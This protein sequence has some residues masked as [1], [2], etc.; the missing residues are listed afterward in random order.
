MTSVA[1][2]QGPNERRGGHY[3]H[4]AAP[5]SAEISAPEQ[6]LAQVGATSS[7]GFCPFPR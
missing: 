3:Y 7:N 2:T 1:P 6:R 5:A 4:V